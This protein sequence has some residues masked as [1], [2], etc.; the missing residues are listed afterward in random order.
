MIVVTGSCGF[1]GSNLIRALVK[2][3]YPN[4]LGIDYELRNYNLDLYVA[5]TPAE[6][7]YQNLESIHKKRKID[8]IFHEGAISSTTETD[9]NKLFKYNLNCSMKLIYF[10]RDNDICL[11]YASSASVYGNPTI[12]EWN[13]SNKKLDPLNLYANSKRQIDYIAEAVIDSKRQIGRAH[14]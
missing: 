9:N 1:I 14:V 8:I 2:K 4:I 13:S 11:Q 10:C 7:F 3:G 6:N 12:E 5:E